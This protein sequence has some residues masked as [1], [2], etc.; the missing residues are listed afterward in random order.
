MVNA[1]RAELASYLS[2][3]TTKQDDVLV[4]ND[5]VLLAFLSNEKEDAGTSLLKAAVLGDTARVCQL[6]HLGINPSL[7]NDNGFTALHFAAI[8]HRP[9]IMQV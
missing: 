7:A 8:H 1:R 2:S 3:V 9:Y 6:L 5:D 4:L